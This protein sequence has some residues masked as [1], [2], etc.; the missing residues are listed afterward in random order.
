VEKDDKMKERALHKHVRRVENNRNENENLTLCFPREKKRKKLS[1]KKSQGSFFAS[2]KDM[3]THFLEKH[4]IP[5]LSR[6]RSEESARKHGL[7]PV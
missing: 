5:L 2:P 6:G 4:L 1:V 3:M 7:W